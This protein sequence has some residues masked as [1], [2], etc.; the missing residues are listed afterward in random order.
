MKS[1]WLI[2]P[3]VLALALPRQGGA[4]SLCDARLM[5]TPTLR[6]EAALPSARFIVYGTIHNPRLGAG[7]TGESD[8]HIQAILRDHPFL[9]GK[10][11]ITLPRYLAVSDK[12][13]PP[14]FLVFC[15]LL[16]GA[17]DPYRGVPIKSP[18]SV[19]YLKKAL[20]LPAKD[21]LGNLSF[22]FRYLD[23]ADPEVSR[24]AYLEF[25]KTGDADVIRAARKLPVGKLRTWLR[26]PRTPPER[27][28]LYAMLL[29]GAG[30]AAD[31]VLLRDLLGRTDELYRGA[32]DGLLAG[33]L[34]LEPRRGW[35][36]ALS[37][38]R[39]GRQPLTLRLAVVR[40]LRF[41]YN[42]QPKANRANVL[43]GIEAMLIEGELADLA[44]EDLRRWEIWDLTRE[45]LALWGKKGYDAPLMQRA[46]VRYALCCKPT[47]ESLDFLARRR[48][49]DP[50]LVKEVEEALRLEKAR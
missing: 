38:L 15:D 49:D 5:Q 35:E 40:T 28:G 19:A 21:T 30:N 45:V 41:Q 16:K 26:D 31:A 4:C 8:M 32:A 17:P 11:V 25:A 14:K 39:D 20:A 44:V 10:K 37:L 42:A 9:K 18:G 33:Y 23:D 36:L 50:E 27:L 13:D 12:K 2:V 24:D 7:G 34:Q 3:A 46:L 1:R 6:Q 22:F 47:R 48:A 29:G 43:K